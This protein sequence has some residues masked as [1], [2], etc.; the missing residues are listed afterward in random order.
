MQRSASRLTRILACAAVPVMLVVAGCSSDS[1]DSGSGSGGSKDKGGAS[2]SATPKP[3]QTTK[4]VEP[5]KFA[6]LP[7]ACKAIS[8]KTTAALVPKAKTKNG[9]PAP[10]SDLASRGGCSWNGLADKGVKGSQYRWLDVSFYRYESDVTLGSGQER[11][12]VNFAKELAKIEETPGA[13]KLRTVTAT[14]IGDEAK[15]V[16]YQLRKTDEDFVYGSVVARSGNILVLL[17]YNGAG[18]AGAP[19]PSEKSIV[20]GAVKAAKEA[21]VAVAAANK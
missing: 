17:S 12:R 21:V 8:A 14:G 16:A 3:S 13:K 15:T 11:A 6:K 7:Q 9:T 2:A 20:D 5:A 18:Y 10:S 19:T 4:T 1:G